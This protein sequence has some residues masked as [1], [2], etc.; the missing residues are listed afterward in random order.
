MHSGSDELGLSGKGP[1]YGHHSEMA[2]SAIMPE[3]G[4]VVIGA[5]SVSIVGGLSL[6]THR[7]RFRAASAKG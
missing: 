6:R 4:G 3:L 5:S 1:A 2:L 7:G